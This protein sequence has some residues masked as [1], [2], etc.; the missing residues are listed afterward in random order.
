VGEWEV[1]G[2]VWSEDSLV[3]GIIDGKD[4]GGLLEIGGK[5][6]CCISLCMSATAWRTFKSDRRIVLWLLLM[7]LYIVFSVSDF[8]S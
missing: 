4:Q 7:Y 1:G 8:C 5:G 3:A 6:K 2:S